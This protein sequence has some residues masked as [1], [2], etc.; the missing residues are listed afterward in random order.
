MVKY[1][2]KFLLM[3]VL[4]IFLVSC[5]STSYVQLP[6]P[7]AACP[8]QFSWRGL[9]PGISTKEDVITVL[10]NPENIEQ[11]KYDQKKVLTFTY[12]LGEGYLNDLLVTRILFRQDG[13]I[14]SLEV[15]ASQG[16]IHFRSTMDIYNELGA[17]D[18]IYTNNNYNPAYSTLDVKGGPAKVFV[19]SKCGLAV[20]GIPNYSIDGNQQITPLSKKETGQLPDPLE[21]LY[22]PPFNAES[23]TISSFEA[24]I[25][26]EILFIPTTYEG[27]INQYL[28]YLPY[29]DWI[30]WD[31][32]IDR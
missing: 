1:P 4:A 26:M 16:D 19:W 22:P 24:A 20:L 5:Q 25:L 6:T 21:V 17:I 8:S 11:N 27:F 23:E 18:T 10:G 32:I 7:S 31:K 28:Y 12:R 2:S 13:I 14:D 9:Q 15:P 29:I 30:L 3:I